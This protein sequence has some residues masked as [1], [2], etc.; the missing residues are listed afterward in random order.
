MRPHVPPQQIGPPRPL[1]PDNFPNK[2]V[3]LTVALPPDL[4]NL[5]WSRGVA[6]E[7]GPRRGEG[8]AGRVIDD[9]THIPAEFRRLCRG[10]TG[11]AQHGAVGVGKIDHELATKIHP[12]TAGSVV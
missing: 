3:K 11:W 12:F 9:H 2:D 6:I 4:S 1:L 8:S 10:R 7:R 5:K